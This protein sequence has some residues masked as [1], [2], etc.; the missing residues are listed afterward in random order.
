[1]CCDDND[2]MIDEELFIKSYKESLKKVKKCAFEDGLEKGVE[3]GVLKNRLDVA[4]HL[5]KENVSLDI[6]SR[7]TDFSQ[8][9]LRSTINILNINYVFS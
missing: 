6:I 7:V 3:K 1:M 5:L 2:Y 9:F 4:I 8:E